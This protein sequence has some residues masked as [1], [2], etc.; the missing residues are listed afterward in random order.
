MIKKTAFAVFVS[1]AILAGSDTGIV[2][3]TTQAVKTITHEP[4][5][6]VI[7]F[8]RDSGAI[9]A[10]VFYEEVVRI[11]D[12]TNSI[13]ASIKPLKRA[14]LTWFDVTNSV[15]AMATALQQFNSAAK[16]SLTNSAI[17]N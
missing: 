8:N 5:D 16:A 1:A 6:V 13:V 12:G 10:E 15:P 3:S 9:T 14:R 17:S 7:N 4:R 11:S 2:I